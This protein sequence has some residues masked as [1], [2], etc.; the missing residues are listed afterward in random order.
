MGNILQKSHASSDRQSHWPGV[1]PRGSGD[2]W[3]LE[4]NKDLGGTQPLRPR[5]RLAPGCPVGGG[6][7]CSVEPYPGPCT[8]PPPPPLGAHQV[9]TLTPCA[10]AAHKYQPGHP[11]APAPAASPGF[12][13]GDRLLPSPWIGWWSLISFSIALVLLPTGIQHTCFPTRL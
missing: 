12:T 3:T 9:A 7:Y 10:P 1:T 11:P 5:E 8:V 4:T 2:S 13:L 6:M